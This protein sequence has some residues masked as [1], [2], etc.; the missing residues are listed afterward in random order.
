MVGTYSAASATTGTT[1]AR[2][3]RPALLKGTTPRDAVPGWSL[4]EGNALIFTRAA[5]RQ[6]DGRPTSK[7]SDGL[8][9]PA[10]SQ[11]AGRTHFFAVH[12]FGAPT[13]LPGQ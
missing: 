10:H 11:L 7:V 6:Y 4:S 8:Y 1:I 13:F 9:L 2:L 5:W 12:P 3:S